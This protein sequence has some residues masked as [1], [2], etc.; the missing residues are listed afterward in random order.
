MTRPNPWLIVPASDYEDHMREAGQFAV[1]RGIFADVYREARPPALAILGCATGNGLELVDPVITSYCVGLDLNPDYLRVVRQRFPNTAFV[2]E[3]RCEDVMRAELPPKRF[4]LVHAALL[5]EYVVE[6]RT[7]LERIRTWLAPEGLCSIVLQLPSETQ[8]MI[9]PSPYRS[10]GALAEIM[11]LH[12]PRAVSQRAKDA[13]LEE[14]KAWE[15]PVAGGKRFHV[16][17][18]RCLASRH[19]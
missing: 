8:A 11:R 18:F 10:L 14:L 1:L 4:Q 9:T 6:P 19:T 5:L 3:L 12:D 2:L 16:A 7:L 17:L 13:G 15:V